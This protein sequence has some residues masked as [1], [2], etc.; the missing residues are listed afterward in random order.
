[1][2]GPLAELEALGHPYLA[3]Q[4]NEATTAGV[5][6]TAYLGRRP[7]FR[8]LRETLENIPADVVFAIDWLERPDLGERSTCAATSSWTGSGRRREPGQWWS[9][10]PTAP[11]A[12]TRLGA[13]PRTVL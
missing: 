7:R 6:V 11:S 9:F 1:M 10:Q 3:E 12:P 2:S 8:S 13:D 5:E 4:M